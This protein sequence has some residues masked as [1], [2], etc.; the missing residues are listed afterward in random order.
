MKNIYKE[1]SDYG[2][3]CLNRKSVIAYYEIIHNDRLGF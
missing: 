3:I 2:M 1:D